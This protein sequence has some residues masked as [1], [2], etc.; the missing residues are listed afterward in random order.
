MFKKLFQDM[1]SFISLFAL[2]LL[3]NQTVIAADKI[4]YPKSLQDIVIQK[5]SS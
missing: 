5:E 3:F 2:T 4:N 1:P